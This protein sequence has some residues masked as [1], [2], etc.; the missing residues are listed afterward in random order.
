[1]DADTADLAEFAATFG[2]ASFRVEESFGDGFVRLR[3]DEAERR[4]AQQDIRCV[5]SALVELLRNARDAH[6]KHIF[7]ATTREDDLRT[8]TVLDD[9]CG[10]PDAM[11][12][13]IFDARVTSKLETAH[14]DHWGVH[15]RGM[16]LYS[17][18]MN[19]ERARVVASAPG[20]GT[21]LQLLTKPSQLSERADQSSWPQLGTNED[22]EM[23]LVRGPHNI[24]R[25]CASFA[26]EE[27]A[28]CR[29]YIGSPAEIV[30]TIRARIH[31]HA[32]DDDPLFLKGLD[33]LPFLEQ[34]AA[35][36]DAAELTSRAAGLGLDISERTAHRILAHTIHPQRSVYSVLVHAD[37]KKRAVRDVDLLQDQRRLRISK[38][39]IHT[40]S[41]MM[42]RDFSWLAQRY[43]LDL[44][45][46]P[47]VSV[48]RGKVTVT[49]DLA[50]DD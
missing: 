24:I 13:R 31:P 34:L 9:G 37:T 18:R 2:G 43:Y 42:E 20:R 8:T 50:A 11:H 7:V 1:M 48:S 49:F 21:S 36:A 19:A 29:V 17:I 39:D 32:S 4:Q 23:T 27:K 6:A 35:S 30:A 44:A 45:S 38:D 12:D 26:L 10:I 16:A 3:V 15:G 33:E 25:A 46:R 5:E 40:F 28:R 22:G 14:I 41:E 47:H